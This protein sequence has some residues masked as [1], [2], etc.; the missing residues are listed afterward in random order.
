MPEMNI[1]NPDGTLKSR[2]DFMLDLVEQGMTAGEAAAAADAAG[3]K[4]GYRITHEQMIAITSALAAAKSALSDEFVHNPATRRHA[5]RK[6]DRAFEVI[7]AD[8]EEAQAE[9]EPAGGLASD[10]VGH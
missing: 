6:L 2:G 3:I 1:T 9:I 5:L 4:R 10:T 8:T 7:L